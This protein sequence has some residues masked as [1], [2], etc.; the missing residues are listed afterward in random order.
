MLHIADLARQGRKIIVMG[1]R[2]AQLHVLDGLLCEALGYTGGDG[3]GEVEGEEEE[4]GDARVTR[5]FYTG[6]TP[7]AERQAA[8]HKQVI[9]TTYA[10]SREALDIPA[11]DTL[12]MATPVGTVEQVVGRILRKHPNKKTPLVLDVVDPYSVFDCM[13]WKRRKYYAKQGYERQAAILASDAAGAPAPPPG[14]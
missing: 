1:D 2:V 11:L 6:K 8:E 4:G 13:R 10:M 14:Q 3:E 7:S 9:F 12:V 5:G